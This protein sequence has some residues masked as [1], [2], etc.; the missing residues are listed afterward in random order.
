MIG[1]FESSCLPIVVART[2]ESCLPQ[3]FS[4]LKFQ[5]F[6]MPLHVPPVSRREFLAGTVSAGAALLSLRGLSANEPEVDSD[7]WALLSDTHI[8]A[9]RNEMVRGVKMADN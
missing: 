7:S 6:I 2:R 4:D 3:P 8:W 9:E 5:E 1:C